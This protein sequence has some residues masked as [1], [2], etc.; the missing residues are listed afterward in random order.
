M[1]ASTTRLRAAFSFPT[2]PQWIGSSFLPLVKANDAW[3]NW[4]VLTGTAAIAQVLGKTT[5]IGRL[6]GPPVTAM[7]ITFGLATIG[8]INAGGTAA[9]DF[10]G[11]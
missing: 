6:L 4:S 2:T 11:C 5:A 9:A 8:V 10:V 1:K 7:A 3:G